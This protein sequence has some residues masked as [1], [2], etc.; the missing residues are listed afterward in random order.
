MGQ[1]EE[2]PTDQPSEHQD[3]DADPQQPYGLLPVLGRADLAQSLRLPGALP[4]LDQHRQRGVQQG[5]SGHGQRAGDLVDAVGRDESVVGDGAVPVAVGG[6]VGF[7]G[8]LRRGG[9][10]GVASV[11][12][13]HEWTL[14]AEVG[15]TGG[16]RPIA[17]ARDPGGL[18]AV[19]QRMDEA[20]L[21]RL[22][23][24]QGE[25]EPLITRSEGRAVVQLLQH[26]AGQPGELA[27]IADE[28]MT[29][30][31]RRLPTE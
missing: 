20:H 14:P 5:P 11:D 31:A 17:T 15:R 2:V 21:W 12:V 29:R 25:R 9:L 10:A 7:G 27:D 22:I 26:L 23:E 3:A 24:D 4:A 30:L 1:S 16:F 28:L 13:A 19:G 6:G 18:G 8:P